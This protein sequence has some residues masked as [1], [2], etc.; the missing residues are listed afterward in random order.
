MMLVEMVPI[1]KLKPDP[2]NPRRNDAA[3][4]AVAAS[5]REFGVRQPIVVDEDYVIVVGHTRYKAAL[6][7]A[8]A[9]V[10]VHVVVGLTPDQARA[11]RIADN[12]T[13][14]LADWDDAGLV[15]ELTALQDAGFDLS[16]TGLATDD[17]AALLAPPPIEPPADPDDVPEPPTDPVTKPGDVWALGQ[18]RLVR[19]DATDPDIIGLA[20]ENRPADLLLT[21]PPYNVA[22]SGKTSTE[23]TIAND[24]LDDGAFRRFLGTALRAASSPLK[25]GAGFYVWHADLHGLTARLAAAD[26][27]LTVRQ[28]L[29]WAKSAFTLGRSD[30]HWKHEPCLYG[31]T[32]GTAHEWLGG[33]DQ[34]TVLEFDRPAR[35]GEHPR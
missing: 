35:N 34:S 8:L 2:G 23:M 22:Y 6:M 9:E 25:P 27:G 33:R 17:L 16:L 1:A 29:V 26:A 10:P 11:Y 28:V 7:L 12:Q 5:I 31:W 19:G 4:D 14:T 20:L 32:G 15:A 24:D 13:A 30:Y 3:V 21:D 18:H